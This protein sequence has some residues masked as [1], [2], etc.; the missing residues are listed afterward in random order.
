MIL[1]NAFAE[2]ELASLLEG[3]SYAIDLAEGRNLQHAQNVTLL[4]LQIGAKLGLTSQERDSLYQAGLL[5]DITVT[6]Q[7]R[8]CPLCE[9]IE[10]YNLQQ[11][12]PSL[13]QADAVIH[14]SLETWEGSGAQGL[15]GENI[16]L[17]SRLLTI[18]VSI[19]NSVPEKRNFEQWRINVVELLGQGK[20]LFFDPRLVDLV[21]SLLR[22]RR[23]CLDV[24]EPN[25]GE[26]IRHYRPTASIPFSSDLLLIIGEIFAK[27]I[28]RKS[29]YTAHHSQ[30]VAKVAEFMAKKIN[31]PEDAVRDVRLA[32]LLHDLGKVAIPNEILEKPGK[33]SKEE[34]AL[35]KNHPYFSAFILDKIP[36]LET[37][38]LWAA[39]HHERLDGSGYY[40]GITAKDLPLEARLIAVADVYAALAAD[41]P[42]RPG[43]EHKEIGKIMREMV[44]SGHLDGQ[45]VEVALVF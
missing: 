32:G 26:K 20:G 1:P 5:H 7:E 10:E 12:I 6:S 36:G 45:L 16:P 30:D 27:F 9:A 21:K 38:S 41:R 29:R 2:F 13:F 8:L 11:H 4:A 17:V 15:Q 19:E 28:D 34:F 44:H 43:L 33:L 35:I 18:A 25:P 22:D 14:G 42:Y 37:I 23:F 39:A 40:L 31:L 3:L 24:L